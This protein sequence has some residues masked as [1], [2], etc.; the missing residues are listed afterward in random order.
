M[1]RIGG[2]TCGQV[3]YEL[4]GEPIR[5]G[6]CH[7]G[8]CRKVTGSAFNY[9]GVWTRAR[10]TIS[11][12]LGCWEVRAGGER[13]CPRCGSALFCWDD[14][15]EEVEV[16]LGTLDEAPAGLTPSYELWTIR[17]EA[18]LG[19]QDGAEQCHRDRED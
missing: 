18:W 1:T 2:C 8:N 3:R 12:E 19:S 9:Y 16:K 10:V 6:L 4:E 14:R 5:V 17:R 13:F 7:C 11:G 15:S